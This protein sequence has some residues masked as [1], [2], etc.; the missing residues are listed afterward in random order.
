MKIDQRIRI[1]IKTNYA[2]VFY[3]ILLQT[4][5]FWV[6]TIII[7]GFVCGPTDRWQPQRV[8]ILGD[9]FSFDT[10]RAVSGTSDFEYFFS[11]EVH[12][13]DDPDHHGFAACRR[14]IFDRFDTVFRASRSCPYRLIPFAT[15]AN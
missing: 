11:L 7:R 9:V 4:M 1:H 3:L 14:Q 15:F 6:K 2:F 5:R 10:L 12:V 13:F 8:R